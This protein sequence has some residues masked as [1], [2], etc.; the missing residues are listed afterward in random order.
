MISTDVVNYINQFP[1]F[2]ASI[3]TAG[4]VAVESVMWAGHLTYYPKDGKV[5][6]SNVK[7]IGDVEGSIKDLAEMQSGVGALHIL[8][9][10]MS[11]ELLGQIILKL[12]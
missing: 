8:S 9:C 10:G 2:K 7:A 11:H 3:P 12:A 1:G 5:D 6:I 4:H